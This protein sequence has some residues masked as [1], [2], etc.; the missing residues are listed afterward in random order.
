[1]R[2]RRIE[3]GVIPQETA[4]ALDFEL[5]ALIERV[6]ERLEANERVEGKGGLA[7]TDDDPQ[8]HTDSSLGDIGQAGYFARQDDRDLMIDR[9]ADGLAHLLFSLALVGRE[10]P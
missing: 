2:G 8:F 9:A 3:A 6:Q 1:M 10:E 7:W 4:A 5:E